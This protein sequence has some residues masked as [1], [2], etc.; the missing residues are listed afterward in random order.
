MHY[1]RRPDIC[2]ERTSGNYG[3]VSMAW[4]NSN[5]DVMAKVT[6][7]NTIRVS[8]QLIYM[9]YNVGDQREAIVYCLCRSLVDM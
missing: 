2:G 9:I 4:K 5:H 7:K 3:K 8:V 1:S 6:R